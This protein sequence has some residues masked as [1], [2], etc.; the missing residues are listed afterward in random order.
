MHALGFIHEHSRTDRDEYIRVVWDNIDEKF[1]SQFQIVPEAFMDPVRGTE[2]DFN[3][4]MIYRPDSFA[5]EPGLTTL[6]SISDNDQINP[7]Q[8][9]LSAED[10]RR[11][12]YLFAR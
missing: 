12:E 7:V 2:F 9:G 6:E 5:K 10:L 1:H 11:L 4:A 3:S 8:A